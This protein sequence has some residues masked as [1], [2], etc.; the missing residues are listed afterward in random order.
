M[1]LF[2]ASA[3]SDIMKCY[4]LSSTPCA[5]SFNNVYFGVTD[6]FERSAEI[7]LSDRVYVRFDPEHALP[8]G[9]FLTE[10]IRFKPPRGCSVYLLP[11]AIAVYAHD[12]PPDDFSVKVVTQARFG[13]VLATVYRQGAYQLS[14]ESPKGFFTTPLPPCFAECTLSYQAE[15]LFLRSKTHIA[16]YALNAQCVLSE[17]IL[18][19]ELTETELN[20][21]LPLSDSRKR[22]ANCVWSLKNGNCVQTKF[23][24]Q[25]PSVGIEELLPYAF[26]ES[27]LIGANYEEL[28]SPE[29][30][31][32][33]DKI[34][35]FLGDFEAVTLT[36][37]ANVCG[38]VKKK[39]ERL[40]EVEYY[41]AECENGKITDIKR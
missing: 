18:D 17:E 41:T 24:V 25:E 22:K 12:F 34:R 35:A 20:A 39:A 3:Y 33:R 6:T 14:V 9:F 38:L 4:F 27:V 7:S 40:Y 26:F 16:V 23:S 32:D 8:I 31:P 2:S 13:N 5:L 19:C 21:T 30:Q 36:D 10:E 15:L 1:H 28:L 37:D 29:L 11:N